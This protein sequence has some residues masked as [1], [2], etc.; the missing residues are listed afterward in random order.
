MKK[1]AKNYY[2]EINTALHSYENLKSWH[3]KSIS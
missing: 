1:K 2:E 3:D